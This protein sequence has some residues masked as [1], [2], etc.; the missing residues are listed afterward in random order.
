MLA[1]YQFITSSGSAFA[2]NSVIVSPIQIVTSSPIGAS[3][4]GQ[5]QVGASIAKSALQ[6]VVVFVTVTIIFIPSEISEI[7]KRPPPLFVIVPEVTTTSSAFVVIS[8]V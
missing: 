5:I 2:T 6:F 1:L 7:E 8:T 4:I 3:T